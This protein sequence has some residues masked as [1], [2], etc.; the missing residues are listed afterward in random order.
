M[1]A[2]YESSVNASWRSG[3]KAMIIKSVPIDDRNI[4]VFA[5]RGT[6]TFLDWA[7]NFKSG[8][9]SPIGF[10]VRNHP[11]FPTYQHN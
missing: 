7:V 1:V 6:A 2:D 9:A 5:I 11:F 8:P 3:T 10:L 4:I